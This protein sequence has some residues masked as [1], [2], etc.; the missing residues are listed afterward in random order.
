MA[1]REFRKRPTL[2][3][4][5]KAHPAMM[6]PRS[7]IAAL[8]L[9]ALAALGG[10]GCEKDPN[11][12]SAADRARCAHVNR[13]DTVWGEYLYNVCLNNPWPT[14]LPPATQEGL[15]TFG[16]IINDTL[17]FVAGSPRAFPDQTA[18][19]KLTYVSDAGAGRYRRIFGGFGTYQAIDSSGLRITLLV[20][21]N[22]Q[23][24]HRVANRHQQF[25]VTSHDPSINGFYYIDTTRYSIH[26]SRWDD[27]VVAGTIDAWFVHSQDSSKQ[28]HLSDGRFD[29]TVRP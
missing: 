10:V 7:P 24:E 26:I 29:L 21:P 8:A 25:V 14:E 15:S 19:A 6:M 4:R 1:T 28:L 27:E 9:V 13:T 11:G 16:G 23:L 17:L 18:Q 22:G 12:P 20:L 5:R 3:M 2:R